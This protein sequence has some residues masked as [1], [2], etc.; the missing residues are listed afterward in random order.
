MLNPSTSSAVKDHL[1]L[2]LAEGWRI[3][4]GQ[5][6]HVERVRPALTAV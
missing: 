5:E 1:T 6:E 3:K 4:H 2:I